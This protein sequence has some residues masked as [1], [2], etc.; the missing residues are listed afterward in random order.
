MNKARRASL[1]KA[2]DLISAAKEEE[3]E[4]FENLP[5]SL[6][7]SERGE[8]MQENFDQLEE[9]QGILEEVLER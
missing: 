2:L 8:A 7:E 1:Q 4:A 3:E 6:Q 5:E 9:I